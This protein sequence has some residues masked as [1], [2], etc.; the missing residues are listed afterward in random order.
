MPSSAPPLSPSSVPRPARIVRLAWLV[1]AVLL[2]FSIAAPLNQFKVPPILPIVMQ[3]F[4]ISVSQAGSLMS[5][6]AVTGLILALPA[7][8]IFQKVGYRLTSVL[9][10]GSIVVGAV[11]GALS[12]NVTSVFAS[13]VVEG[14]GTSFIAVVAPAVIAIWFGANRR[15]IAMGIWSMWVPLGSIIMLFLAPLLAQSENWRSV[16]WFGALYALAVTGLFLAFV[17]PTPATA[18]PPAQPAIAAPAAG[19]TGRVLRNINLWLISLTFAFFN[20]AYIGFSTYI[21]TY[22]ST[23]QNIPLTQA[24]EWASLG[25]IA[26]IFSAPLAGIFS[27]R[28]GSRKIPYLLGL[29]L[30]GVAAPLAGFATGNVLIA[31]I[32][33]QGLVAGLVPPNI[34]SAAVE[35]VGDEQLGGLAMG[36]VMVGQNAGQLLGPIVFGA[37]AESAWGW[38]VAFG[39]LA[40][41]FLAAIAAGAAAK[42]KDIR[43]VESRQSPANP[44]T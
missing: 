26:S 24:A 11:W 33:F 31:L 13:R 39:S 29:A 4:N 16:W 37:L 22:L 34:F 2:L 43:S 21:P 3:A 9:A 8:L 1:L 23:V 7:G 28:V 27:D 44:A 10:G 35:V 40:L 17:K 19:S 6:Y 38:P 36:V 30:G 41:I 5:L 12:L 42:L 32:A 25:A 20:M 14:I 18:T 15:G